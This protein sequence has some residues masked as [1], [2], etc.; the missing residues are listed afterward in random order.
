MFEVVRRPSSARY[1]WERDTQSGAGDPLSLPAYAC[2]R[3][4]S[5]KSGHPRQWSPIRTS[6]EFT[7]GGASTKVE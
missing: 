1:N 4:A 6:E 7:I 3:K 5:L 2:I